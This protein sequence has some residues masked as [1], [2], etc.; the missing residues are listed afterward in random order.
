[1]SSRWGGWLVTTEAAESSS[2]QLNLEPRIESKIV[3]NLELPPAFAKAEE[4]G[5]A[6]VQKMSEVMGAKLASIENT[7]TSLM[8]IIGNICG[9]LCA[10]TLSAVGNLQLDSMYGG[11]GGHSASGLNASGLSPMA[12]K[13]LDS[14]SELSG[15]SRS[16]L[17]AGKYSADDLWGIFCEV[18]GET[19]FP[20]KSFLVVLVTSLI[21]SL[22]NA[23]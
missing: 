6:L 12:I 4:N 21:P 17:I 15:I 14:L 11:L 3:T 13:N 22:S 18:F 10:H 19:F 2:M 8:S 16:D 23:A 9:P 5:Q 7:L 1:M 20:I